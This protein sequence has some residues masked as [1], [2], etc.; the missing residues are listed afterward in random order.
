MTD[1][2]IQ[3]RIG[4]LGLRGFPNVMGGVERH[5]EQ[6]YPRIAMLGHRII[7]CRRKPYLNKRNCERDY[8]NIR[9]IDLWAPK[10]K[11]LEA[12]VHSFLSVIAILLC[13]VNVVHIHSFGPGLFAP[14]LKMFG[15]KVV[16]TYHL[17]NYVQGK[18]NAIDRYLLKTF[19][20]IA[21]GFS[22][23]IIAVS[24]CN[25]QIVKQNTKM[26]SIYIPNG[27][28]R[29]KGPFGSVA[30]Y[31]LE[32]K[33]YILSACRFVP[34]KGIHILEKAFLMLKT[35]WKLVIAGG[36][37]HESTYAREV[38]RT[39]QMNNNIVL[40]GIL[41]GLELESLYANAGLFVLPSFIEGQPISLLEAM[42]H[43]LPCIVSDI[44]AHLEMKFSQD[45]YFACGNVTS[46]TN[47]LEQAIGDKYFLNSGSKYSDLISKIYNWDK[48]AEQ[49]IKVYQKTCM[50]LQK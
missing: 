15:I 36:A 16:L 24:E 46:L 20:K 37:D 19:E 27:V 10:S 6:L 39:A 48:I 30:K 18:W 29:P 28:N 17:P 14:I 26:D 21:C 7:V 47:K 9:F 25:R 22:D 13:K 8:E 12:L 45:C 41:N 38:V 31:S 5:C 23:E 40:T 49:T 44:P 42:S 35:D 50:M 3:L 43:E 32:P 4:V 2:Q 11:H 1:R 34:E 33:H